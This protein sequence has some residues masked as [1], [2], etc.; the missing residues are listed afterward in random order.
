[1]APVDVTKASLLDYL[2]GTKVR[3]LGPN[4]DADLLGIK[5]DFHYHSAFLAV[6]E[7]GDLIREHDSQ[8]LNILHSLFDCV[9]VIEEERR[10]RADQQ[11]K[12][13][14]PQISLLGGTTPA[15]ISRTFPA[16]AWDEGF[17]ARSILIYNGDIIEPDL[18]DEE[19]PDP[20][21]ARELVEDLRQ[22]GKMSGRM[23]FSIDAKNSIRAWQKNGK[24]PA[25]VHPRLEHYKTRRLVHAL[26]LSLISAANRSN[27]NIITA[28][29]FQTALQWMVEAEHHMPQIFMEM[30][31]RSDN[32]VFNELY[33][34]VSGVYETP[35]NQ[36]RPL[37]HGQ[38]VNWLRHKV[39]AVTIKT[40][41]ET[42]VEA[43]I[44]NRISIADPRGNISQAY[45]PGKRPNLLKI[46]LN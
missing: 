18:F 41:L 16:S 31:G 13:K 2:A 34:F 1:M 3:R 8:L 14:Y 30:V 28:D 6:S 27:G 40:I 45:T 21:V 38:I 12:I 10:Y 46:R 7:L 15:Y 26:K 42:A 32:Q 19:D 9:P 29:D 5:E 39:P 23:E 22:I 20:L 25:P 44:L 11:L 43:D 36:K 37:P 33:Q 4:P 17:M 35:L 24:E